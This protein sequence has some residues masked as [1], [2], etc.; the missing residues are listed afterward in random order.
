VRVDKH[1]WSDGSPSYS[2]LIQMSDG[3]QLKSGSSWSREEIEELV[4]SVSKF[5]GLG[6]AA[7]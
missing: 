5:L 1:D 3:S 7:E 2:L 4:E 6:R